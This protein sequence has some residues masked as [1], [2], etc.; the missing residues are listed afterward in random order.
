MMEMMKGAF[1]KGGGCDMMSKGSKGGGCDDGKGSWKGESKGKGGGKSEE[2]LGN[3]VGIIKSFNAKS[4]YGFIECEDL[5][6]LGCN[7][8]V[9]L[10]HKEFEG[11]EVGAWVKFTAFMNSKGQPQAKELKSCADDYSQ[12]S[13]KVCVTW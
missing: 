8:D 6:N 5:S 13:K 7:K 10:L 12:P 3:F 1:G 2:L 9:F 11:Y 4:G